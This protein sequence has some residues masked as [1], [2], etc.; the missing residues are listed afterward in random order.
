LTL[1][2]IGGNRSR[3]DDTALV[4][5]LLEEA[6]AALGLEPA[7][8][9]VVLPYYNGVAPDD[10]GVSGFAFLAGGHVT[11]HTF[12]ARECFF[13]DILAPGDFDTAA[14]E[15]VICTSLP[16]THVES[17]VLPRSREHFAP[18]LEADS[19]F[20]PHLTLQVE[21]YC[22]PRSMDDLFAVFDCLPEQI[23]MTPIMR[24]YI[25]KSR[26]SDGSAVTSA[27]TML[28]ESHVAMHIFEQSNSAYFDV[29]SCAFFDVEGVAEALKA[30]FAGK[31]HVLQLQVRGRHYRELW[32]A[33]KQEQ[34]R[35]KPWLKSRPE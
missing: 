14:A 24:P 12:S 9:P 15:Q 21:G 7:M 17:Q 28:A 10:C 20:G 16:A 34:S 31:S 29:F 4:F 25:L 27:L 23:D 35:S 6:P 11:L 18:G 19:D 3:Y 32:S 22:G 8:P 26:M 33:R 30:R 2:G 1:E 5:E 13:A